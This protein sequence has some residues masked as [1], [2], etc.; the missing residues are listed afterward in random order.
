MSKFGLGKG[1]SDLKA[2]FG[3]IPDISI[4][5]G[6]DKIVVRQVPLIQ[7]GVNS[8]QPRKFFNQEELNDLA[9]SIKEKGVLQPIL[10]RS[11]KNKPYLYEI[12]A[13]ERRFRASKIAGLSEIPALIKNID[14]FNAMEIALIENVQRENLNPIEE[15][16]AYKNLLDKDYS[17]EDICRLI[18]KSE[19]Y[20]R[21]IMRILSLPDSVKELVI[22]GKL[23]ASHA[24]AISVVENPLNI[25]NKIIKE[26]IP[27]SE[28]EK[29]VKLEKR[30]SKNR[31]FNNNLLVNSDILE[32]EKKIKKELNVNVKIKEKKGGAGEISLYFINRI[33]LKE[34]IYN[35][36]NEEIEI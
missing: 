16:N 12:I 18:G 13:G 30:A 6:N 24:R 26:N 9:N 29:M 21:N 15:A 17:V 19:S 33:Q 34:L 5:S 28:I 2:E 3:D 35:L 4:L 25:A 8:E 10:L 7:I 32:I 31:I 11:I 27:V 36:I 1:L 14:D 20:I 22:N 23:S